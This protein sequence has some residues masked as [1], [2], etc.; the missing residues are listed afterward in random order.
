MVYYFDTTISVPPAFLERARAHAAATGEPL[1]EYGL[2]NYSVIIG[3]DNTCGFGEYRLF[4]PDTPWYPEVTWEELADREGRSV[5]ELA[6]E[7]GIECPNPEDEVPDEYLG[8]REPSGDKLSEPYSELMPWFHVW[9]ATRP[10]TDAYVEFVDGPC[11][12]NDY[13]GVH[14]YSPVALACLQR[15]LDQQ[16][17]GI[18]IEVIP[19]DP[20]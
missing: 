14:A 9:A 15:Y 3:A 18:R 1:L 2:P 19:L 6:E 17:A 7:W 4:D 13:C 8:E 11:P 10:S 20:C 16:D 5:E 12:G